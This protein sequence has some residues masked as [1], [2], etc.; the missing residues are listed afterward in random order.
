MIRRSPS[1]LLPRRRWTSNA[2]TVAAVVLVTAVLASPAAGAATGVGPAAPGAP[3][4]SAVPGGSRALVH[5]EVLRQAA[6]GGR[7]SVIAELAAPTAASAPFGSNEAGRRQAAT[8]GALGRAEAAIPAAARHRVQGLG[9][10][11]LAVFDIDATALDALAG[12]PDVTRIYPNGAHRA[13]LATSVPKIG[14]DVAQAS[15]YTGLGQTVAILDTGVDASHPFLGGRVVDQACFSTED[16]AHGMTGFCPGPDPTEAYGPG[17]GGPCSLSGC[18]H[19]THVAGI[20]AGK[21]VSFSGVAPDATIISVQVFTRVND[22]G[23]CGGS[24]PCELFMDWDLDRGLDYVYSLTGVHS[25]SSANMSLGGFPIAGWCDF[26]SEKPFIDALKAKGVASLIAAGNDGSKVGIS[27]PGCIS[28]AISVGATDKVSDV[29]ASFSNSSNHLALLAPG[30]SINSSVPGGGFGFKSG[31]SMATP[32]VTGAFAVLRQAHPTMTV[33]D[34]TSLL[35]NTGVP[36]T[37]PVN[38][39]TTPRIRVDAAVRPPTFH[40]LPPARV[41]DT[42]DGTGTGVTFPVGPG[43]TITVPLLGTGGLPASG[44]SGVVLNLTG[45][46]PTADTHLT[47]FPAG[48]AMPSTSSLNLPAGDVRPNLVT[49]QLGAGGAVSVYNNSGWIQ[50]VADVAGWFDAGGVADTGAHHEATLPLRIADTQDGTGGLP[51]AKVGAGQTITVDVGS[52]CPSPGAVSASLNITATGGDAA[53]HLTAY[54]SGTGLPLASNV[55]VSAGETAPNA[56]IVA[57]SPGG[58]IDIT[59]H[60]G[61]IDVIVDLFGCDVPGSSTDLGGRFVPAQPVRVVDTRT[62]LGTPMAEPLGPLNGLAVQLTGRGGVP[63]T[64]VRA[65]AVNITETGATAPSHISVSPTGQSL[66]ITLQ[67]ANTSVLNFDAGQTVANLVIAKVGPD[68]QLVLGNIAG[69]AHVIVDVVGW[70]TD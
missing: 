64:G 12:S 4:S 26:A 53:T 58:Q 8:R 18:S 48:F 9:H 3:G 46:L 28:S 19:G 41:I 49:V 29:V 57:L 16:P 25:I 21:G 54:P 70:V 2:A 23:A 11:P 5:P 37:D 7:I 62:G 45:V 43:Q 40:P 60:S 68:G 33:D 36:I 52:Q 47:A 35:R 34:I 44:V 6:G 65:V 69:Q 30:V 22:A 10:F 17:A 66:A 61:T 51:V 1:R 31:T 38:D 15:G 67:L 42:R 55:N 56:A 14:G 50:V 24:A 20:A 39:I 27:V 32:H 63:S 59:N 13:A